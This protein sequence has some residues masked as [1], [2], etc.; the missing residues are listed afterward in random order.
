[1]VTIFGDA[2]VPRGGVL[3]LASLLRLTRAFRLAD[4]L[5]R[6]ALSRLVADGWFGRS[7]AGRNSFYRLTSGG[8]ATFAEATRR[9]YD[10]AERPWG[11]E[12]DAVL[13]DGEDRERFRAACAAGGYG[14]LT[15]EL[16]IA[17]PGAGP[18]AASAGPVLRLTVAA[19]DRALAARL[20]QRSWP[21]DNVERRYARF[22]ELYEPV[23]A[24]ARQRRDW[25]E[26]EAL[27][28][29][30][31]L[32]H[33][34]RRVVLADPHLPGV[35]LPPDW[36]GERARA[37]CGESYR[38]VAGPAE[39]WLDRWGERDGG[40]LPPPDANFYRRFAAS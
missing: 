37:L 1:M 27:I 24:T 17:P 14:Q 38:A 30:I 2:V 23:A 7:K 18:L 36:N 35:L 33:D 8:S 25:G 12:F 4:G 29:R 22:V 28:V 32:I 13:L 19:Q 6:T 16:M 9:I 11:G 10:N 3:S 39:R 26:L 34:F 15:G 20:A 40:P 5:V 21:L 31:L